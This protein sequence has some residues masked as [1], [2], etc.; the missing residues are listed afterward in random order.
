[1]L[2]NGCFGQ[3]QRIFKN[4]NDEVILLIKEAI[5]IECDLGCVEDIM[6]CTLPPDGE[7][8]FA[9]RGHD[10]YSVCVFFHIDG[11]G[12][13]CNIPNPFEKD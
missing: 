2:R 9:V 4:V 13:F 7:N 11:E 5:I 12:Y 8:L 10:L 6:K 1:M 3:V